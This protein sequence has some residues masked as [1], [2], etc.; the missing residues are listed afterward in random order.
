MGILITDLN[1]A[2]ENLS[3][4]F[5]ALVLFFRNLKEVTQSFHSHFGAFLNRTFMRAI[6]CLNA[7]AGI[8]QVGNFDFR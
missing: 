6:Q 3:I 2:G 7:M 1:A 4:Y 8:G 5:E